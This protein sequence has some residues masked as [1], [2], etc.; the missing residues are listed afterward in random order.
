MNAR[1]K[2]AI[3]AAT[4]KTQMI[5]SIVAADRSGCR[6]IASRSRLGCVYRPAGGVA[7][8]LFGLNASSMFPP[9]WPNIA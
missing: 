1:G 8:Q 4:T 7:A 2:R 9:V 3:M 5:A 6:A